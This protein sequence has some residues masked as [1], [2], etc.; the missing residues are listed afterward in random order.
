MPAKESQTGTFPLPGLIPA[1]FAEM[2]KKRIE[3]FVNA[4]TELLNKLQETNSQWFDRVKTEADLTS[5]FAAKL[6]AAR[7][8]PEIATVYQ[9]WTSR[10]ME[11]AAEDAKRIFSDGQKFAE[12]SAHLLSGLGLKFQSESKTANRSI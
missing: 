4:Q 8:I 10:H 2:G 7:S 12:T 9:E 11:M 1:Q 3:E 5:E 6:T